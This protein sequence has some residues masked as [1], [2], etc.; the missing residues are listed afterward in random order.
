M[1]TLICPIVYFSKLYDSYV[2][3]FEFN[4]GLECSKSPM[5]TILLPFNLSNQIIT[6]KFLF[7]FLL[8]L[9]IVI[10]FLCF[11]FFWFCFWFCFFVFL[12]HVI[13]SHDVPSGIFA[14]PTVFSLKFS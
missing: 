14:M 1:I 13:F 11:F 9:L 2:F 5:K 6:S 12:C 8:S 10:S 7:L 3:V 4:K